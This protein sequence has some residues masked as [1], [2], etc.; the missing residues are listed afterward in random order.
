MGTLRS[1]S[2]CVPTSP[3]L[4][5]PWLSRDSNSLQNPDFPCLNLSF[6]PLHHTGSQWGKG[7]L[8]LPFIHRQWVGEDENLVDF[9]HLFP[10]ADAVEHSQVGPACFYYVD[11]L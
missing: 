9:P 6:G 10:K 2:N 7:S 3:P 1:I 5:V 11:Q 4:E 8:V